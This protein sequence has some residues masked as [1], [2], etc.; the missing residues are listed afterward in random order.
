MPLH[1]SFATV[2]PR[3]VTDLRKQLDEDAQAA[4][5]VFASVDEARGLLG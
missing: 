2:L 4:S 3:I 1:V 5:A